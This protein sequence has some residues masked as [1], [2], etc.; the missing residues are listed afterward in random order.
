MNN[1]SQIEKV[2]TSIINHQCEEKV[3]NKDIKDEDISIHSNE[4]ESEDMKL[5]VSKRY[6]KFSF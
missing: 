4:L 1:E 3:K 5:K 2:L 6:F